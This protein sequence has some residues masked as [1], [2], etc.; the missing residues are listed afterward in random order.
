MGRHLGIGA[1]AT[2][3][4]GCRVVGEAVGHRFDQRWAFST[5]GTRDRIADDGSH[6]NDVVAVHLLS[7]D[8]GSHRLLG[9][10][11]AGIVYATD[12]RASTRVTAVTVPDRANVPAG[13]GGV[14]AVLQGWLGST[15]HCAN[16]MSPNFTEI[17]VA[18]VQAGGSDPYGKYWTMDL[19]RPR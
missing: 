19:A 2:R 14:D 4:I 8:T 11:D 6:R 9:E 15:G 18:C 5:A 17:A 13:Y 1:I 10:G 7:R 3:I 12:A 16:L